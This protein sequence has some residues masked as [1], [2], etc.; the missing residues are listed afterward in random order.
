MTPVALLLE[1]A[2]IVTSN[3]YTA[4][5]LACS[6]TANFS[7]SVFVPL[8]NAATELEFLTAWLRSALLLSSEMILTTDVRASKE[9]HPVSAPPQALNKSRTRSHHEVRAYI[10]AIA[11]S[12]CSRYPIY[13]HWL[14]SQSRGRGT[15]PAS[16][17]HKRL[18]LLRIYPQRQTI[19]RALCTTQNRK[20]AA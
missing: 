14:D 7:A 20:G 2:S 6:Q 13:R 19:R 10:S 1:F 4:P 5:S 18:R 16:R 3:S 8:T 15:L 17:Q 12:G 9:S 11:P